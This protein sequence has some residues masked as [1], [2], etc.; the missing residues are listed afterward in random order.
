[1]S[2]LPLD[3]Q[4]RFEQRW[5]SRFPPPIA[6]NAAKACI[7]ESHTVNAL[8]VAASRSKDQSKTRWASTGSPVSIKADFCAPDAS[9]RDRSPVGLRDS[10][11]R[12]PFSR[13]PPLRRARAESESQMI[14]P[15]R[16]AAEQVEDEAARRALNPI[17]SRQTISDSQAEPEFQEDHKRLKAQRL[18]RE[19]ADLKAKGK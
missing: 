3:L 19:A 8:Q 5:A 10:L 18:A 1:M 11:T 7:A 17:G 6:S 4:R 12:H 16:T 13:C 2:I 14:K 15:K 9:R